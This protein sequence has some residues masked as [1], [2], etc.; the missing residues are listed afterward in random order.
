MKLKTISRVGGGLEASVGCM[1]EG[2]AYGFAS[3][4]NSSIDHALRASDNA[5]KLL[6]YALAVADYSTATIVGL[7]GLYAIAEGLTDTVKGSHHYLGLR[8]W[9]KFT[10]SEETRREIKRD[11]ESIK[12]CE[13][14]G[15]H[16]GING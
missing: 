5:N 9:G 11:I 2:V 6:A 12:N 14:P 8:I 15:P 3:F 7:F 10:K 1:F 16:G 13:N 4:G